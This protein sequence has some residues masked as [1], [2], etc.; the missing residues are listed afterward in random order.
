MVSSRSHIVN[1]EAGRV[2]TAANQSRIVKVSQIKSTCHR[3]VVGCYVCL[4]MDLII[5]SP[6]DEVS[7]W[8][9]AVVKYS[10]LD[11]CNNI[12]SVSIHF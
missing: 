9:L 7:T 8:Q 6:T 11:Q 10:G 5:H 4:K 3:L 1:T 2:I 12:V